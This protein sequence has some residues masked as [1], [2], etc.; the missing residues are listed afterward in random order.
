MSLFALSIIAAVLAKRAFELPLPVKPNWLLD[1]DG[2]DKFVRANIA[3]S[4]HIA[5]VSTAEV[6]SWK[7]TW[8]NR[9]TWLLV[10]A[11]FVAP[12]AFI[13]PEQVVTRSGFPEPRTR[14]P[15]PSNFQRVEGGDMA[16]PIPERP[17][18]EAPQPVQIP[19]QVPERLD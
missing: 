12:L 18:V 10:T 19:Q 14:L 4:Y 6:T 13:G 15:E 17:P 5:A 3:A 1:L 2:D 8:V 16:R 7:S 9:S 11:L